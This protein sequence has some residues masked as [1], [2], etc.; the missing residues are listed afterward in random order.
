MSYLLD[1]REKVVKY[2]ERNNNII[3][4]LCSLILS[5]NVFATT[6]VNEILIYEGTIKPL[7]SEPLEPYFN[8]QQHP[9]PKN[10][11]CGGISTG[12][13]RGYIGT[14]EI[15]ENKLYLIKLV[16][17][18][19]SG[20]PP[21][22][23]LTKIF[24]NQPAPIKATWF[25]GTLKVPLGKSLYDGLIYEKELLFTVK[26]SVV[27]SKKLVDNSNKELPIEHEI[28]LEELRKLNEW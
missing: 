25:S 15:K 27:I 24:P 10:I 5:A 17:G 26:N 12:N 21:E 3:A 6:Q 19:C 28:T 1:L 7:S 20:N 13:W 22:I 4:I 8:E 9:R 16:K 2:V 23:P 14:W 11:T 18:N